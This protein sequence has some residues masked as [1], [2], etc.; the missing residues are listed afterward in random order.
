MDKTLSVTTA[1]I[2]IVTSFFVGYSLNKPDSTSIEIQNQISSLQQQNNQLQNQ[3][4]QLISQIDNL[5]KNSPSMEFLLEY[6]FYG[7]P[8]NSVNLKVSSKRIILKQS[9]NRNST[10]KSKDLTEEAWKVLTSFFVNSGIFDVEQ[11]DLISCEAEKQNC[12]MDGGG[13]TLKIVHGNRSVFLNIGSYIISQ[14]AE[15]DNALNKVMELI[16]ELRTDL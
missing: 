3:N 14:P 9:I 7:W 10:T 8:E 15:L 13:G 12:S 16:R 4:N 1:I 5:Q 11:N 2:L 6:T